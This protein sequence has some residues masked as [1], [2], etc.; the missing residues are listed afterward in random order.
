MRP[1][2]KAERAR[3]GL[4][5]KQVAHQIGVHENALLKWERG[6]AEPLADNLIRLAHLYGCTP[7]YLMGYTDDRNGVAVARS[8]T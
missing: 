4:T 3:A 7:D 2:M 8:E 1:N 5:G 6:E